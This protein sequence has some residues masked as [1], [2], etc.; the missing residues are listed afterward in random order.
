LKNADGIISVSEPLT[1]HFRLRTPNTL[2]KKY[3]TITNGFQIA[4]FAQF[5]DR[6]KNGFFHLVYTGMFYG[7]HTPMNFF[8]ALQDACKK[9]PVFGEKVRVTMVGTLPEESL[10]ILKEEPWREIVRF[11]PYL[12][13]SDIYRILAQADALLLI[14]AKEMKDF[15]SSKLFEYLA[16]RRYIIAIVPPDGIAAD[17]IRRFE[18]GTVASADD[19]DA[20]ASALL[21]VFQ[22]FKSGKLKVRHSLTDLSEF[23]WVELCAKLAGF[24]RDIVKET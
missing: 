17:L 24:F 20:I 11:Q 1:E 5:P 15:Y 8:S 22:Q 16:A 3:L 2:N 12:P 13:H 10:E 21:E 4:D 14:L 23:S 7:H 6:T 9:N 19:V 18:A